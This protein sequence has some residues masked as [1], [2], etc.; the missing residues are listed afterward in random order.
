M[1]GHGVTEGAL[2]PRSRWDI[3]RNLRNFVVAENEGHIFGMASITIYDKRIAEI[4][5][6]YVSPAHR[7]NGTAKEL[8]HKVMKKPK[9]VTTVFAITTTPHLFEA[10]GYQGTQGERHILFKNT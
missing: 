5:S 7:K 6:V 9:K 10:D 2:K 8:I 4:R 3:A 1:L